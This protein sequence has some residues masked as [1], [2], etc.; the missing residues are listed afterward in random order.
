[1]ENRY[2]VVY[3]GEL[4]PYVSAQ[5]AVRNVAVLFKVNENSIRGLVLGGRPRDIKVDLDK[6]T[7][8]RYI[9]ALSKAGLVVRVEPMVQVQTRLHVAPLAA[10]E[11]AVAAGAGDKCPKCG[12]AAVQDG[13]CG[14]CGVVVAKYLARLT[15]GGSA[16]PL[17]GAAPGPARAPANPY[18]PPRA[19]LTPERGPQAEE[20]LTGPHA[21]PIGHG[22]D[23]I[24]RGFWHFRT[25]PW[26]WI[27]IMVAYFLVSL[28]VS[29]VPFVGAIAVYLVMPVLTGGLMLGAYAQ[30]HGERLGFHHLF[31]G[32]S[33]Q[34]GPLLAA[35]VLYL[36][37]IV[38]AAI[39]ALL[40]VGIPT[41]R[42]MAG[43]DPAAFDQHQQF[44]AGEIEGLMGGPNVVLAILVAALLMI[45]VAMAYWF[46]PALIAIDGLNAWPAMKLSF[47]G[48]VKNI[49]PFLLYGIAGLVLIVLGSIPVLLGLLVVMPT[50]TASIYTAY[51]DIFYGK[52]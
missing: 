3:T 19:E 11:A 21:V 41:M 2:K 48:C 14:A 29:L 4:Q 50:L 40:L 20:I 44:M 8:D 18:A 26:A 24:G 7:A 46:A 15:A 1:M 22:W 6:A 16:V 13:V 43:M 34:T 35:G 27:L 49:L 47:R 31:A 37:G 45:P 42:T 30:G 28:V 33:N 36:V 12:A 25:N 17:P 5:E 10:A 38:L 23:W 39:P 52:V 51:R 32:F 9:G